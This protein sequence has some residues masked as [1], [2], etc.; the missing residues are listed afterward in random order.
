M[1][2]SRINF[3]SGNPRKSSCIVCDRDI[4]FLGYHGQKTSLL[5]E[6]DDQLERTCN[7]LEINAKG[8][9]GKVEPIR[10]VDQEK[11]GIWKKL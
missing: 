7:D 1:E 11:E 6:F 8:T 9:I 5:M 10:L 4:R 3:E 2:L